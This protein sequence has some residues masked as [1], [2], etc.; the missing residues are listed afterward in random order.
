MLAGRP[1]LTWSLQTL[2]DFGCSSIVVAVPGPHLEMAEEM[3][4]PF[5]TAS[6][7]EGGASRQESVANGLRHVS[8][9][10]VIVHDAARPFISVDLVKRVVDGL[11]AFDGAIAAEPV[12][13]TLKDVDG[14]RVAVTVDRARMWRA[15]TPQAFRTPILKRAHDLARVRALAATDDAELV[16]RA[17]GTVGVVRGDR[18]NIK[19]TYDEDFVVAESIAERWP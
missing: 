6:V 12:E 8:A 2:S 4:R 10:L 14:E 11:A 9:E 17:G 18:R 3:A 13:D 19:L 1:L 16:E 5:E 15:Q 7:I